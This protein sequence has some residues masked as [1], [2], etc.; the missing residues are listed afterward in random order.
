MRELALTVGQAGDAGQGGDGDAGHLA[1][2]GGC[3]GGGGAATA[4]A[5][6]GAGADHSAAA[7]GAPAVT[8]SSSAGGHLVMVLLV[9]GL[10]LLMVVG[11]VL[12][13]LLV[14]V[15]VGG[16]LGVAIWKRDNSSMPE[17]R[18]GRDRSGQELTPVHVSPRKGAA[19]VLRVRRSP[20]RRR[21]RRAGGW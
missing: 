16:Q 6:G 18:S 9:G 12:L 15:Q 1:V 3:G 2:H 4:A 14:L 7:D 19:R 8:A 21:C 5:R 17:T 13:L 11:E 20:A 10:E